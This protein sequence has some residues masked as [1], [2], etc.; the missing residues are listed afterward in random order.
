MEEVQQVLA[1]LIKGQIVKCDYSSA[2]SRLTLNGPLYTTEVIDVNIASIVNKCRKY[3]TE[4]YC[5]VSSRNSTKANV[6]S[7]LTVFKD[8]NPEV[9][10]EVIPMLMKRMVDAK[11][12]DNPEYIPNIIKY[13]NSNHDQS[14]A[15][16]DLLLHY[17]EYILN[18]LNTDNNDSGRS[19]AFV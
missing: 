18:E 17:E 6:L 11:I 13:I 10:I 4:S 16:K 3:F 1:V 2:D 9:P 19:E 8:N 12:A 5:G 7:N 14:Y 15:N